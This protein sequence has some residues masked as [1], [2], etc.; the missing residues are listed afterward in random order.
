MKDIVLNSLSTNDYLRR[1]LA[2]KG[3]TA[4]PF[5]LAS[6]RPS[7]D[8]DMSVIGEIDVDDIAK[9][10]MLSINRNL[11]ARSL[12]TV[13]L[14]TT[15]IPRTTQTALPFWGGYT[16]KFKVLS[17][18]DFANYQINESQKESL[19]PGRYQKRKDAILRSCL[20][21]FG[22]SPTFVIEISKYEV[23][24]YSEMKDFGEGGGI[25][26]YSAI[27][28]VAEKVRSVC[29]QSKNYRESVGSVERPRAKDFYDIYRFVNS[30]VTLEELNSDL[31]L[32]ILK[33]MFYTKRVF[34]ETI[35][36]ISKE[37]HESSFGELVDTL[38]AAEKNEAIQNGFGFYFDFFQKTILPILLRLVPT[39]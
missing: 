18:R 33:E 7:M 19:P 28:L 1:I 16:I 9:R 21:I 26:V 13:D 2:L 34:P 25:L 3:G 5:Y 12:I 38:G 27:A 4:M 36:E 14:K 17:M 15:E 20:Q 11:A 30:V 8:I 23:I 32:K 24:E 6:S 37:F 10:L 29:Q 35:N 39:P 22:N 31:F